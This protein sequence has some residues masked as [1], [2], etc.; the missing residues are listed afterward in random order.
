[1]KMEHME[2]LY[3]LFSTQQMSFEELA[4][5]P[6]EYFLKRDAKDIFFLEWNSGWTLRRKRII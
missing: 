1:M 2:L 3:W 4:L 6:P 5:K